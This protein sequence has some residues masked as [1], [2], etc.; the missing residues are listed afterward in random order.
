METLRGLHLEG[1][2]SSTGEWSRGAAASEETEKEGGNRF[3]RAK[4]YLIGA[5]SFQRLKP[6]SDTIR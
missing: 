3:R 2:V 4:S 1:G 6:G 5:G